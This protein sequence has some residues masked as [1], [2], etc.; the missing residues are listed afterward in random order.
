MKVQNINIFLT[1]LDLGN[2][3]SSMRNDELDLNPIFSWVEWLDPMATEI[4]SR[5]A[6]W[7]SKQALDRPHP[8]AVFGVV[9]K[10]VGDAD[11]ELI[12]RL[13]PGKILQIEL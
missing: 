11:G 3:M 6:R 4:A 9:G 8:F 5:A 7:R 10:G 1:L 2:R 13:T 12:S